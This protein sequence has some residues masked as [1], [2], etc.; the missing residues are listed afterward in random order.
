MPQNNR[1]PGA[2]RELLNFQQRSFV[3]D[4]W[5]NLSPTGP[6]ATQFTVHGSL[7]PRT[8]TEAVTAARLE[9]RQPYVLTIRYSAAARG[10]TPAW[11][12]VDSRDDT[13][14]FAVVSPLADP[15]GRNAWLECLVVEGGES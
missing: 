3:D 4:G 11:R 1:R 2:L 9:G 15:D 5:G 10:V 8:G 12:V 7:T 14:V 13:R 6:F